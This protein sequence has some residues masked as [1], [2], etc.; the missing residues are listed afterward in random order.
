MQHVNKFFK[1]SYFLSDIRECDSQNDCNVCVTGYC[2][3]ESASYNCATCS[4]AM[5]PLLLNHLFNMFLID[6]NEC[7]TGSVCGSGGIC[8]NN[9]GSYN[10]ICTQGYTG[11]TT[12][13]GNQLTQVYLHGFIEE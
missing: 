5:R 8:V 6:I 13:E 7:S 3:E 10:C 2:V 4:Q 1:S 9:E 11:S 12:C